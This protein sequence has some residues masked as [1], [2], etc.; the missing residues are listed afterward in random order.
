[1]GN[2]EGDW[3]LRWDYDRTKPA[4]P[5]TIEGMIKWINIRQKAIDDAK[6]DT[7]HKDVELYH[8][9]ELNLSDLAVNGEDCVTN[10]VLPLQIQIMYRFL[11]IRQQIL[12]LLKKKWIRC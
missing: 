5:K 11:H 1:M 12:L 10:S 8:Y 2:W 3:H 7:P 4:N 9:L 6:K